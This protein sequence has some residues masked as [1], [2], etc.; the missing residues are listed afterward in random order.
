MAD[1][2]GQR[3]MQPRPAECNQEPEEV[4]LVRSSG[5]EAA[6]VSRASQ[7]SSA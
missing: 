4:L 7:P 6:L 2:L 3:L 1:E 5:R